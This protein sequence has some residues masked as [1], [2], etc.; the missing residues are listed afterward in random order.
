MSYQATDVR[1]LIIEKLNSNRLRSEV[2][3][4]IEICLRRN[5]LTIA[6]SSLLT[7]ILFNAVSRLLIQAGL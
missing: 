7:W 1:V 6:G 4:I 2:M 3:D 5:T